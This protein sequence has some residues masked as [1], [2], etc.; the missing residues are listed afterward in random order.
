MDLLPFR[1][2]PH[3]YGSGMTR[4]TR[5][6]TTKP[7]GRCLAT[8]VLRSTRVSGGR[9]RSR[10]PPWASSARSWPS[11]RASRTRTSPTSRRA[12]AGPGSRS[13][14][15]IAEALQRSPSELMREAEIYR[16]RISGEEVE[17][18]RL[19]PGSSPEGEIQARM[20]RMSEAAPSPAARRWFHAGRMLAEAEMEVASRGDGRRL[21][22]STGPGRRS[23]RVA[24]R[25]CTGWWMGC[26][27]RMPRWCWRWCAD[28]ELG[29]SASERA[30]ALSATL[31][32]RRG[33]HHGRSY[34]PR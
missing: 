23:R 33:T 13:F 29:D 3:G 22:R 21:T 6:G 16:A 28:C 4:E 34:A 31:N 27:R 18:Q 8:K 19:V 15:A 2:Y 30:S 25:S 14:L 10:G 1:A 20:A 26:R 7:A 32:S 17:P 24:A 5:G 12:G 9:S 11:W